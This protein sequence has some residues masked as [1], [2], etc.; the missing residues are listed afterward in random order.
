MRFRTL[1]ALVAAALLV[2]LPVAAQEQRG[3]IDG[4][5]KDAQGGAIVGASVVAKSMAGATV[6]SVTDATGKYRFPSLAPG[7]YEVTAN[8]SG[9][10]P[11]KVENVDLRLGQLLSINLTPQPRRDDRDRPGR[12]RVPAHRR[13]AERPRDLSIRAEEHREA[14]Q[15]PRLH[16]RSSRRP[17]APTSRPRKL[18][19]I[20]ID[21]ASAGE[22]R[23]IVDG[24]ETTNLA[25]RHLGQGHG[26]RLR[27][28]GPGQVLGLRRRV[29][30]RDRRRHQRRSP[31]AGRTACAATRFTYYSGDSLDSGDRAHACGS[32]RRTRTRPSTSPT[33]RTTTAACEPG[34]TLGGPIVKDKLWFFVGYDPTFQST[35]RTVTV[36][37]RRLAEHH[38]PGRSSGNNVTANITAQFGAKT[39]GQAW[40]SSRAATSRRAGCRRWTAP[41]APPRTTTSTTSARTTAVRP[42]STTPRRTRSS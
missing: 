4:V 3:S 15:G 36:A 28:R 23:F 42:A 10:A 22:N 17:P 6:E 38:E 33:P 31:A 34:F 26:H 24:A 20:S 18:G 5:V 32:C 29:R 7:R 21:G 41:A 39:A 1:A 14:A 19:G 2:A 27:R 40:P 25:E 11:A 37:R 12:G 9:F 8:L 13:Q 30:R 16:A 35:D